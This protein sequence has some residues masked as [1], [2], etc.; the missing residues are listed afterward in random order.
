MPSSSPF[1]EHVYIGYLAGEK[2]D[3]EPTDKP[4]HVK[5]TSFKK[6]KHWVE[7]DLVDRPKRVPAPG[8][9]V[10]MQKTPHELIAAN[11]VK[12]FFARPSPKD[13]YKEEPRGDG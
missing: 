5:A 10:Y 3:G 6:A 13:V 8:V 12:A 1:P 2:K 7:K 11:N 9:L 4:F